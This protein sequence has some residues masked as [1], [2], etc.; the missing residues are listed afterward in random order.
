MV[1]GARHNIHIEYAYILY[2]FR[3]GLTEFHRMTA[4][5]LVTFKIIT[6]LGITPAQRKKCCHNTHAHD[7][8][9]DTCERQAKD[10]QGS[11][12]KIAATAGAPLN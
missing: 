10:R 1:E 3:K 5:L 12:Q 7:K 6:P 8:Q 2:V 11:S 9:L 4:E